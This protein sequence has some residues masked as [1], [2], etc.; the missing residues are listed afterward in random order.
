M[1]RPAGGAINGCS[2]VISC[3]LV[4]AWLYQKAMAVLCF[5]VCADL[6]IIWGGGGE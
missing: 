2:V 4:V 6:A 3:V 5:S 1:V